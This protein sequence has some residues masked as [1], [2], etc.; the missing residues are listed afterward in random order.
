[1]RGAKQLGRAASVLAVALASVVMAP[2]LL[3]FPYK[4]QIGNATIWSEA[5]ITPALSAVMKRADARIA[6]SEIAG[7]RPTA[8]RLFLTQ[9]GW[10][11]R[12]LALQTAGTFAFSRW[13]APAIILNRS[14]GAADR[15][16]NGGDIGG[17]RILS[18][19][20][21]HEEAHLAL[22]NRYGWR[23]VLLPRW[24]VEGYCDHVAGSS[25][26]SDAQ[27]AALKAKRVPHPA[28]I[29]HDGRRA[30]EAIL[31]A[32]GG[33]IDALFALHP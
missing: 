24:K 26:L 10:R 16:W 3:A 13:L 33:S 29:Y 14:D 5:P 12:V 25:S 28:L 18:D 17:E 19:V 4:T 30:V 9:G 22:R 15:I 20:I 31:R 7:N 6:A 32:N 27:A 11:W 21:A 2:Q 1:M 8:P 23:A